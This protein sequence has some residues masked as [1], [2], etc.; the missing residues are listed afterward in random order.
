MIYEKYAEISKLMKE[1][2][3]AR[4]KMSW[5]EIKSKVKNKKVSSIDEKNSSI[6]V[7]I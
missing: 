5:Q 3:E 6:T 4:K 7:D 1:L 2:E